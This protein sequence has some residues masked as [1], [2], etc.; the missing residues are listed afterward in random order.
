[1][2]RRRRILIILLIIVSCEFSLIKCIWKSQMPLG[3]FFSLHSEVTKNSEFCAKLK[4]V[5]LTTTEIKNGATPFS[6]FAYRQC[7]D[8]FHW[9]TARRAGKIISFFRFFLSGDAQLYVAGSSEMLFMTNIWP[10]LQ[11]RR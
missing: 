6:T 10:I 9:L 5:N 11:R 7:G 3:L 2:R 4:F 1:M 8:A